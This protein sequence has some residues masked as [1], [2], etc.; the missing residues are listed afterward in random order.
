MRI[1]LAAILFAYGMFI[2]GQASYRKGFEQGRSLG[3]L[4][5]NQLT[6]AQQHEFREMI[7]DPLHQVEP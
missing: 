1:I 7:T 6:Q 4:T 3:E 2:F 5:W